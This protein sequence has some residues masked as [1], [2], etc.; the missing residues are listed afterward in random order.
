[1]SSCDKC[2]A[3]PAHCA[4]RTCNHAFHLV[5]GLLP[6][7]L[8]IVFLAGPGA[9]EAPA[10]DVPATLDL[11]PAER[12]FIQEHPVVT[13]GAGESFDPFINRNPDGSLSGI[14]I[15]VTRLI[16]EKTGLT[17]RFTLGEWKDIVKRAERGELDGLSSTIAHPNR[18]RFFNFTTPYAEY[19]NVIITAKGNPKEIHGLKDLDGKRAAV[20]SG[21]LNNLRTVRR[22]GVDVEIVREKDAHDVLRSV[23][24]GR[25]DFTVSGEPAFY[26][27]AKLG[28]AGF[29]ETAFPTGEITKLRFSIRKDLPLLV[30]IIDKA[31]RAIPTDAIVAIR[32]KWLSGA[33][34]TPANSDGS[35]KLTLK[36]RDY[37]SIHH[38]LGVCVE[39]DRPPFG[40][41]SPN[42]EYRGMDAD[43][44]RLA[45]ASLGSN[46]K[47][48]PI[49]SR[50]P[51]KDLLDNKCDIAAMAEAPDAPEPGVALTTPF[52]SF[53]YVIAATA[54]KRYVTDFRPEDGHVFAVVADSPAIPLLR[55]TYPG[56]HLRT[57]ASM[58]DGMK[59]VLD[60]TFFGMIGQAPAVT[61][62]IQKKF[63]TEL[64]I[65]GQTS[66]TARYSV[67]T[68]AS[69]PEL[70]DILQKIV[71]NFKDSEKQRVVNKWMAV[72][73]E[74]GMDTVLIR[75][76]LLGAAVLLAAAL[77]W[78]WT[79]GR[80]KRRA[81]TALAAEREAVRANLNFIDMISHEYRSP[82]SVISSNLDL[83]EEKTE[84]GVEGNMDRELTR[85]RN[86]TRRL[87]NIF[88]SSLTKIRVEN[89][90][91]RPSVRPIDLG[92]L[93]RT[94]SRDI[95]NAYPKHTIETPPEKAFL[96]AECDPDLINTAVL[97][98]LDNACKYSK[99]DRPV[100]VSLETKDGKAVITVRDGGAG[101][102][103]E[104]LGRIFEKYYRGR[105][106]GEKRGAG[107]GLHLVKTIAGLHGGA[108]RAASTS[109]EGTVVTIELPL[110]QTKRG[111]Q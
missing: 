72:K 76:I 46:A 42:G 52:L 62:A 31:L 77:F 99:A 48:L 5:V 69:P 103:G 11:T 14:D 36:E 17:F 92:R 82:L 74:K 33:A 30:S 9:L 109:G 47:L 24:M 91:M 64:K 38:T 57:T 41:F 75:N 73:Y 53:P 44:I 85:M 51:F 70:I 3:A 67:A 61:Y 93:L 106:V 110:A 19:S 98:V 22:A 90:G 86:A 49:K 37:L 32:T 94:A 83:I 29:L 40:W 16:S 97:N 50:A 95:K 34:W 45:D 54:D 68:R 1:M 59:G 20:M 100:A 80:A 78:S 102:P 35:I 71:G 55:R 6:V 18:S 58:D 43:F 65:I 87:V 39:D 56:I 88:T 104:D 21:N 8:A 25:A 2:V 66:L 27:T 60:G 28:L 89:A 107:I 23:A 13:I 10:G 84:N 63:L 101:V 7:V 4:G 111:R 12:R 105:N 96:I 81:E 26:I 15:D 108:A 79:L